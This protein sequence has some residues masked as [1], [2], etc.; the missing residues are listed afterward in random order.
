MSVCWMDGCDRGKARVF[1]FALYD[2][3][4]GVTWEV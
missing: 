1:D 4:N 3:S 2:L